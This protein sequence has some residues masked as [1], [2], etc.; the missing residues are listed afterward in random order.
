L[1]TLAT[2]ADD[3]AKAALAARALTIASEIGAKFDAEYEPPKAETA[4][5]FAEMQRYWTAPVPFGTLP[6]PPPPELY[7]KQ[8]AALQ[9]CAAICQAYDADARKLAE[10]GAPQLKT[11][12]DALA[13]DARGALATLQGMLKVAGPGGPV[14]AGPG[15]MMLDPFGN[16]APVP[17][18]FG[19]GP[20]FPMPFGGPGPFTPPMFGGPMFGGPFPPMPFP[21]MPFPPPMPFAGPPG[22][23]GPM[24]PFPAMGG[25]GMTPEQIKI[26]ADANAAVTQTILDTNA[27][28]QGVYDAAN[29]DFSDYLKS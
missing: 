27:H 13:A 1:Q 18:G 19:P 21:P 23:G 20:M 25:G 24:A 4:A 7:Q 5:L 28:T 10:A 26:M 6:V 3:A 9:Q 22:F 12:V 17:S 8:S 29:A 16:Y 2:D 15:P 11:Y 14:G